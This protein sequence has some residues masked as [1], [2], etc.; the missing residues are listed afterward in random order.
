MSLR[1]ERVIILDRDGVI[2][3][4]S[5][6]YIKSLA[7]WK[8]L[9][10][11]IDA[12]VRLS[13]AGYRIAIASNQSGIGRN[14]FPLG[15]LNAMHQLLRELVVAQGGRIEMIAFCPHTPNEHCDCRKPNTGLLKEIANRMN[16]SLV[17]VPLIGD[18]VS[19]IIAARRVGATPWLVMTG[20]GKRTLAQLRAQDE[21]F[22]DLL[23]CSDLC[24]AVS[25]L[26][27]REN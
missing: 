3:E 16:I 23:V 21:I 10:R 15:E 1:S 27:N 5:D 6:D 26:L 24:A 22:D 20:K 25:V 13:H 2:N 4:D 11:S 14:L 9:P 17:G 18:S 19:D 7:E 12:I 8:P